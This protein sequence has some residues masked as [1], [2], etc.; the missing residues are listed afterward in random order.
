MKKVLFVATV[1]AL[2][3]LAAAAA[4]VGGTTWGTVSRDA[5]QITRMTTVYA[6]SPSKAKPGLAIALGIQAQQA[7]QDI[8]TLYAIDTTQLTSDD[9][10]AYFDALTAL[11]VALRNAASVCTLNSATATATTLTTTLNSLIGYALYTGQVNAAFEDKMSN[12]AASDDWH[13]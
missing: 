5:D 11:N 12:T 2:L 7:A 6:N 8:Q 3:S 1:L 10:S 4:P 9:L 13:T